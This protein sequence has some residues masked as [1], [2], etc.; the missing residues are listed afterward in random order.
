[1]REETR[2]AAGPHGGE[3]AGGEGTAGAVAV[4]RTSA[5]AELYRTRN[6]QLIAYATA[7]TGSPQAAEDLVAEAHFRVWRRLRAGHEVDN[8]PA[9]LTTTVRNLAAGLGHAQ[10]EIARDW[11]E[12]PTAPANA[13]DAGPEQR[14]SHV[15]LLTRLLK[16]LPERW[17]TAL[18]YAEVED[19]P[20]EGV[21]AHIG[22]SA[23]TAAV[24]VTRA[25]ERLRQA[26]LQATT[27]QPAA[28][29]DD[30]CAEYWQL[31]PSV[32]R[33]TASMRRT[34]KVNEH[35]DEC[36]D[37]RA[38]LL[39]LTE[40][41]TRLPILLGPA[42][43]AGVLARGGSWLL[44]AVSG[45]AAKSGVGA[46]AASASTKA[47]VGAKAGAVA[48]T[49]SRAAAR[50]AR[51]KTGLP[52]HVP[53][54][55][56]A[57][58]ISPAKGVLAG[59]VGVVGIAAAATALALAAHG[60]HHVATAAARPTS[61]AMAPAPA[62]AATFP[63]A[64]ANPANS[65]QA[66]AA[67]PAPSSAAGTGVGATVAANVPASAATPE[68]QLSA[69]TQSATNPAQT[70]VIIRSLSQAPSASQSSMKPVNAPSLAAP[71]LTPIKP[72]STP[73]L[74]PTLSPTTSAPVPTTS[75]APTPSS[76]SPT[77][78]ATPTQTPSTPTP[79]PTRTQTSP[80]PTSTPT[81]ASPETSTPTTPT[82]T[83]SPTSASPTSTTP[84]PTSTP[85]GA[86]CDTSGTQVVVVCVSV[87]P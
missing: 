76:T 67:P 11:N 14:A 57:K 60:P 40:A 78:S 58:S 51:V 8:V 70:Q 50:H 59:S 9:Y 49:G 23:S 66:A 72:T 63:G 12:L 45:A 61:A 24:V 1:M 46:A 26:F 19:L 37:C 34:R 74:A 7:L 15:D 83:A 65:D 55:G 33:G 28:P 48:R 10:R 87:Q 29:A 73:T 21:G 53:L 75:S 18:W 13:S 38:R 32:V 84:P 3:S 22:A 82:S 79:T 20:M 39:A 16:E 25:R 54:R 64:P 41:N 42:L 80:S 43:L 71:T 36:P 4:A 81:S 17:A 27:S 35:T 68:S 47:A 5:Y 56:S 86:D 77:S 6:R 31:M 69:L 62:P 85:T 30:A 2:A 52:A 44:P